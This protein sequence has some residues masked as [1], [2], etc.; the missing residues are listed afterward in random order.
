ML[1]R[2]SRAWRFTDQLSTSRSLVR[3]ISSPRQR[4]GASVAPEEQREPEVDDDDGDDRGPDRPAHGHA[5]PGRP[6]RGVVAVVAVDQRHDDREDDHLDDAV[7]DVDPWQ[8]E[9]EVV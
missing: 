8:V 3:A 2:P 4:H 1:T 7:E 6:A 5:H 9:P